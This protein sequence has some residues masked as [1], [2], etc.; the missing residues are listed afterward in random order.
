MVDEAM[1]IGLIG[2]AAGN[3]TL[4][5]EAAEFLLSDCE[6]DQAIYLGE[7]DAAQQVARIWGEEIMGGDASEE[8][9]LQEAKR[10]AIQGDP[11]QLELLLERDAQR[12]RLAALRQV[13]AAPARAVEVME[14]R[15][16][17]FVHDKATL[18]EDDIANASLIVYGKS[19]EPALHRFGPRAFYTPGP[20]S[21]CTVAVIEWREDAV[22]GLSQYNPETGEPTG[23]ET[24]ITPGARLVVQS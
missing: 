10:L 12:R 11:D 6:V 22:L 23:E 7:D 13:P 18:D 15:V 14:D 9:F 4:L 8:G 20:L 17:L 24:L 5:R 3:A 16:L 21:Y 19:R 1:R 2:P